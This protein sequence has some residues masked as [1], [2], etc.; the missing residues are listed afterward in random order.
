M[1]S[2]LVLG[3]GPLTV[4]AAAIAVASLSW[5]IKQLDRLGR[6]IMELIEPLATTDHR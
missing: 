6:V 3:S 1:H 4:V 2:V 5:G